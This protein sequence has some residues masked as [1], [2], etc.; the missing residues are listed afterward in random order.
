MVSS[1]VRSRD[2]VETVRLHKVSVVVLSSNLDEEPL[3][4]FE[5]L[6]QLRASDPGILAIMLL[7]SSKRETILQAF[8][9]G[10]EGFSAGTIP[11]RLSPS[12]FAVFT[13]DRSGP[14]ASRCHLPW[15]R[16]QLLR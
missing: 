6:R 16:W 7:D 12:A 11:W 9:A 5:L 3:R 8:R 13:R 14:T 4:G 1:P 15:R 2:L 10:R